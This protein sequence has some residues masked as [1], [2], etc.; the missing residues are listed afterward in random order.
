MVED[1]EEQVEQEGEE[2]EVPEES[3]VLLARAVAGS[4][5]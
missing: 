5:S 4:G 1:K 3:E 2:N